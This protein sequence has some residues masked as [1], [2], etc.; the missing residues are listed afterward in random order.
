M[1]FWRE[2]TL[3]KNSSFEEKEQK[4]YL[5]LLKIT[6][7]FLRTAFCFFRASFAFFWKK[8]KLITSFGIWAKRPGV[9]AKTLR[10]VLKTAFHISKETMR[11]NWLLEKSPLWILSKKRS[12]LW[13]FQILFFFWARRSPVFNKKNV[14][15]V[16]YLQS[17]CPSLIGKISNFL[18]KNSRRLWKLHSEEVFRMLFL[19]TRFFS[20]ERFSEFAEKLSNVWYTSRLNDETAS[21]LFRGT[22]WSDFF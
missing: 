15:R 17:R 7:F 9:S 14:Y 18:R 6:S 8:S 21:Y 12:D 2:S 19:K 5:I 1:S 11:E 3:I 10:K 16:A 22:I 20:S 4:N 13:K